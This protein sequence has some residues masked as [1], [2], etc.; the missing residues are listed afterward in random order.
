MNTIYNKNLALYNILQFEE[1]LHI[2]TMLKNY[3]ILIELYRNRIAPTQKI[4][5]QLHY[6]S[7]LNLQIHDLIRIFYHMQGPQLLFVL[8]KDLGALQTLH[9]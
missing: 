7:I 9:L 5:V 1:F 3:H 4:I 2:T 8:I 6:S